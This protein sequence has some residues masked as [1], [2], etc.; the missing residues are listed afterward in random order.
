M[1][2]ASRFAY[3]TAQS[4]HDPSPTKL[5]AIPTMQLHSRCALRVF[6][7][8]GASDL[9][10]GQIPPE[11]LEVETILCSIPPPWIETL[12]KA[13]LLWRNLLKENILSVKPRISQL[14]TMVG[15]LSSCTLF[16][17]NA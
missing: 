3:L 7:P 15:C 2:A 10:K 5:C 17:A 13:D 11:C 9:Y 8:D 12:T 4:N 6:Q 14:L 1:G 16:A